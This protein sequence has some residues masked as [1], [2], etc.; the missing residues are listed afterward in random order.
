MGHSFPQSWPRSGRALVPVLGCAVSLVIASLTGCSSGP[1]ILTPEKKQPDPILGEVHPQNQ[2][3]YAPA[4]P[5]DKR[6]SA[7]GTTG[8]P[9]SASRTP[10][11]DPLFPSVPTSN[12][13]LASRSGSLPG[14]R[15]LAIADNKQPGQFQLAGAAT[16][17]VRPVPQDPATKKDTWTAPPSNSTAASGGSFS[18]PSSSPNNFVDPATA[19]LQSRGVTSQRV[20]PLAD[21]TVR[22]TA[23]VPRRD[24]PNRQFTYEAVARDFPAAAQA[25]V[26]QID[27]QK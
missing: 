11:E 21:G 17:I 27:Q 10:V 5:L 23:V 13:Y 1:K 22:L 3:T 25:V 8:T 14:S 2:P 24:D 19:L 12:A 26:Q 9:T 4:A 7:G 15:P 20:E 18:A 16:P 6:P